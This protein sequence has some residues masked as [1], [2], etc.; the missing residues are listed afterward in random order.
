MLYPAFQ[1]EKCDVLEAIN[2]ILADEPA[3]EEG[4]GLSYMGWLALLFTA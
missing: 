3:G 2:G 4:L 1:G